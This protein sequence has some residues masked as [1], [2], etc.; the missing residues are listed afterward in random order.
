MDI[1]TI[2]IYNSGSYVCGRSENR[3]SFQ[4]A[5]DTEKR[6]L[7]AENGISPSELLASKLKALGIPSD[8]GKVIQ[9]FFSACMSVIDKTQKRNRVLQN[10]IKE[11]ENTNR[12]LRN[13]AKKY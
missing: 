13:K 7:C 9:D 8:K 1:R 2:G 10:K 11:L 6:L 4:N 12:R 3:V 5:I